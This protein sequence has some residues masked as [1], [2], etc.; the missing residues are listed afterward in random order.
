MTTQQHKNTIDNNKSNFPHQNLTILLEQA[1]KIPTQLKQKKKKCLPYEDD[2][3]PFEEMN[4]SPNE[5]IKISIK[6]EEINKNLN[7]ENKE[8]KKERE[9]QRPVCV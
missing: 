5:M 3:N 8:R 9:K 6:L 4:K 1:L 7:K 2:R